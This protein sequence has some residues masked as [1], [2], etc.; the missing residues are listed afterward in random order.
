MAATTHTLN[1]LPFENLEHRRF[2]DLVRQLAY[3]FKPWRQLEATGRSGSEG[4]FDARGWEIAQVPDDDHEEDED[5]E[6]HVPVATDRLWLVQCKRERS[7]G[8]SLAMKYLSDVSDADLRSLYGILFVAPANFS[9]TTRDRFIARCR[10][11]GVQ[12][13]QIW[14]RGELEDLLVQPKNDHLLFA[15]FGI[16]LQI[17]RRS[18]RSAIRSRLA[19]KRR[20]HRILES[21][22]YQSV[23]L[24][25]SQ[26]D[27][28]P[29]MTSKEE[30]E[31]DPRWLV[32][33]FLEFNHDGPAFLTR[34]YFA[35]LDENYKWDA[36][37]VFNDAANGWH[38]DPWLGKDLDDKIRSEI[39]AFWETLPEERRA[40]LEVFGIIAYDDIID[41]DEIGDD[42]VDGAPHVFVT[43]DGSR[44]QPFKYVVGRVTT[45]GFSSRSQNV[46]DKKDG[47]IQIF[48]EKFREE[49]S[50]K[51]SKKGTR[52]GK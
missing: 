19:T 52:R 20:A 5:R 25:D 51:G 37:F 27:Q 43:F 6:H 36:A 34:K 15:Y 41:I 45:R 21:K 18:T 32:R 44:V 39:F 42:W 7:I 24:R 9:R 50:V 48:P 49:P 2:E 16:S 47:R 29:F 30:F 12:E 14:G 1:P 4:G 33:K 11:F 31:R 13:I 17:R 26:D 8:P 35:Y 22:A 10:D 3:D 38:D 23:L 28:Y 46:H 40:W